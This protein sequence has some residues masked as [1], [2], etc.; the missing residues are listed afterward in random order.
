MTALVGIVSRQF[1]RTTH[2]PRRLG[3]IMFLLICIT[4]VGIMLL[5]QRFPSMIDYNQHTILAIPAA[6]CPGETFTYPVAI[7]IK[8]GEAVSRVSEGWCRAG[9]GICPRN[10]AI[11]PYYINFIAPYS[12]STTATRTVPADLPPGDWQ[13]RHCNETHSDGTINVTCYQV[14]VTVKDCEEKP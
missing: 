7:A 11:D 13:L 6:V 4:A 8:Q 3:I 14:V 10:F 1:E 12:V 2:S 9:D 5:V